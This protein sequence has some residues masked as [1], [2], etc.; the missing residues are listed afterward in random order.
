MAQA[1]QADSDVG[2][3]IGSPS[4]NEASDVD[5]EVTLESI[6]QRM[7]I[8]SSLV[9]N[10]AAQWGPVEAF[11]EL[12]QNWRDGIIKSF[13]LHEC[14]FQVFHEEVETEINHG[15]R[16]RSGGF[17]WTFNFT[18]QQRLATTLSRMSQTVMGRVVNE[19]RRTAEKS[20]VDVAPAPNE[21]VQF[22]IGGT[23]RGRDEDG[24]DVQRQEVTRDQFIKWTKAALFLQHIPDEGIV[25]TSAGD[26]VLHPP[27]KGSLYMKGLLL[28]ESMSGSASITGKPVGYS[29]NFSTGGTNRERESLHEMLNSEDPEFA[30]VAGAEFHLPNIS[31]QHLK[32]YLL[33]K[34]FEGKW[35]YTDN[36]KARHNRFDEAVH[37]LGRVPER[38][39]D[40]Y[41]K[42]LKR[43]GFRTVAEEEQK[44]FL[45]AET[46]LVPSG[47]FAQDVYRLILAGLSTC[48]LTKDWSLKFA[49]GGE[50][51]T[52]SLLYEHDEHTRVFKYFMVMYNSSDEGSFVVLSEE[53]TPRAATMPDRYSKPLNH[54]VSSAEDTKD[55]ITYTLGDQLES[56]DIM[57]PRK[58]YSASNTAGAK[59]VV[60]IKK[61]GIGRAGEDGN[62]QTPTKRSGVAPPP[63]PA[64]NPKRARLRCSRRN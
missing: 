36:E 10:Y 27:S 12:V 47:G 2:S 53:P 49:K 21:D 38:V 31:M 13:K 29:Y 52:E 16:C 34:D 24:Y 55:D 15:V 26:L 19:A 40:S 14:D 46:V 35:F 7:T 17:D 59:A 42:I 58:W 45:T 57:T 25:K 1:G 4:D 50:L 48:P 22:L 54:R 41:W 6:N 18:T 20:L 5:T 63:T 44:R 62:P 11:R 9:S 30:D 37:G 43:A 61:D 33:S 60:G 23:A 8:K 51:L 28:K 56:L 32:T 64:S 3:S 39:I